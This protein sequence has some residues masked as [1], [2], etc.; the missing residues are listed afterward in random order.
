MNASEIAGIL[1]F[2]KK[3]YCKIAGIRVAEGE[4]VSRKAKERVSEKAWDKLSERSQAHNLTY[5]YTL[6][7]VQTRTPILSLREHAGKCEQEM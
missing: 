4:I 6:T 2:L 1:F 3:S 5:E 7:H